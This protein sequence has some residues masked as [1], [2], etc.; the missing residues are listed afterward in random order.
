MELLADLCKRHALR[1]LS[2]FGSALRR[3]F[4]P[5]SDVDILIELQ[6]GQ[7]M[8]IERFVA[9]R[10][11][12]KAMFH[13]DVDLVEKPLVQNPYRRGEILRTREVLYAA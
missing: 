3:D 4:R 10:D 8:T 5:D 13:R 11:E 6:P 2:V 12:L 7:T 9:I 1:E